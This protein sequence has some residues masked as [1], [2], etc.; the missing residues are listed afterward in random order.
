MNFGCEYKKSKSTES[1]TGFSHTYTV[2]YPAR[3]LKIVT[4]GATSNEIDPEE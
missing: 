4:K 3:K 2:H 1:T